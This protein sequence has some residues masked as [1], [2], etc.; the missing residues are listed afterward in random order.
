LLKVL[1]ELTGDLCALFVQQSE[2][3]D[4]ILSDADRRAGLSA[5]S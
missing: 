3:W 5:I 4:N 2:Q 1:L